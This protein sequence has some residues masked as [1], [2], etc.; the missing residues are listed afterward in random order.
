[1]NKLHYYFQY[2]FSPNLGGKYSQSTGVL[3]LKFQK[4]K[5]LDEILK[6]NVV[7]VQ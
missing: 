1:M 6:H 2:L 3:Q 4:L 5:Y 7:V